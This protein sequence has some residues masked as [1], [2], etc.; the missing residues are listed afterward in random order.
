MDEESGNNDEISESESNGINPM[1]ESDEEIDENTDEPE[2]AEIT[3]LGPPIQLRNTNPINP[4]LVNRILTDNEN[5]R[6]QSNPSQQNRRNNGVRRHSMLPIN[7]RLL[8]AEVAIRNGYHVDITTDQEMEPTE[9]NALTD[10]AL[11]RFINA[12]IGNSEVQT[13]QNPNNDN[14]L[15]DSSPTLLDHF[16]AGCREFIEILMAYSVDIPYVGPHILTAYLF[17]LNSIERTLNSFRSAD[18]NSELSSDDDTI[19]VCSE[20]TLVSETQNFEYQE[21][22]EDIEI[23]IVFLDDRRE[24]LKVY[25]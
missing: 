18:E 10:I 20:E 12:W 22:D 1:S 3:Q 9:L 15:V 2:I 16:L 4:N 24:I 6:N 5:P 8:H 19:S 11:M 13:T 21:S 7:T 25:P 23:K 17:I 14:R